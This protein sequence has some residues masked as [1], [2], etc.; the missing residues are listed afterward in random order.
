MCTLYRYGSVLSSVS[1]PLFREPINSLDVPTSTSKAYE[2]TKQAGEE[3]M[4]GGGGARGRGGEEGYEYV[5]VSAPPP[6]QPVAAGE[7]VYEHIP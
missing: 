1:V 7:G 2:L 5:M 3:G 6:A 4:G